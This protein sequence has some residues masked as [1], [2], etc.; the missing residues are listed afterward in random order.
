M[1]YPSFTKQ[2]C[3]HLRSNSIP[4]QSSSTKTLTWKH[5][6]LIT[7]NGN[8]HNALPSRSVPEVTLAPHCVCAVQVNEGDQGRDNTPH[9]KITTPGIRFLHVYEIFS[10]IFSTTVDKSFTTSSFPK[11]TILNPNSRK[12]FSRLTSSLCCKSWISPSTST[13]NPAL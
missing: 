4:S 12:A 2:T 7:Q 9:Q 11:R 5:N 6:I 3:A 8:R 1:V 13:T 10:R